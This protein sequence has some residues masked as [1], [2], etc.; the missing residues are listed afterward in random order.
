MNDHIEVGSGG[1][2]LWELDG[3][4]EE[5]SEANKSREWPEV[6]FRQGGKGICFSFVIISYH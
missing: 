2:L 3:D 4:L 1:D 6:N 5:D